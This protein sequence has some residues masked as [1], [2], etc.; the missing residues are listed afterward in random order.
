MRYPVP[1]QEPQIPQDG[2]GPPAVTRRDIKIDVP[3]GPAE[4]VV[5]HGKLLERALEDHVTQ[6]RVAQSGHGFC[7]DGHRMAAVCRRT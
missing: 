2:P 1:G 5:M 6:S 7:G 3:R 4:R